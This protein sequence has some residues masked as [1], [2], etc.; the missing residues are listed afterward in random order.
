[1]VGTQAPRDS[2]ACGL[3]ARVCAPLLELAY[4]VPQRLFAEQRHKRFSPELQ[5]GGEDWGEE[6]C[7]INEFKIQVYHLIEHTKIAKDYCLLWSWS[8]H[9]RT[10][11]RMPCKRGNKLVKMRQIICWLLAKFGGAAAINV[12]C[13]VVLKDDLYP[14]IKLSTA[15]NLWWLLNC[16]RVW[17]VGDGGRNEDGPDWWEMG[18]ADGFSLYDFWS[19]K[20]LILK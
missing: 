10:T 17:W 13:P 14:Y 16:F 20:F 19:F 7:A 18:Q 6:M 12:E 9:P 15:Q 4:G 1:M 11:T 5:R 3:L 8:N 2:Q